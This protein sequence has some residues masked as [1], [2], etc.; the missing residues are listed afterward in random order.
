M[1]LETIRPGVAFRANAAASF[2]RIEAQRGTLDV[3]RSTVPY[4]DQ[5][6]LY[7]E[8]CAGKH[9]EIPLVLDPDDS[10]HV[11]RDDDEHSG[12]AVDSDDRGDFWDDHGWLIVN[13]SELWHREYF[14]DHDN[15]LNDTA[16]TTQE[17]DDMILIESLPERGRALIGPGY[18][19]KLKNSEELGLAARIASQQLK[20]NAREFDVWKALA[21]QG[22]T[23]TA[24]VALSAEQIAL[25]E[26]AAREGGADAVRGLEFVVTVES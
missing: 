25:I 5:K 3:N 17:D 18:F 9:P 23:P 11:Y 20:G 19:R 26:Q 13:R 7:D 16:D 15:H 10:V 14:P 1:T 24:T 8:W 12:V 6:K 4:G 22:V 2:R 21:L